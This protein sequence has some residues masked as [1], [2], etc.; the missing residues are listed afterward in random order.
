MSSLM[1]QTHKHNDIASI[2]Q[3]NAANSPNYPNKHWADK[4]T[5]K[6]EKKTNNMG[7]NQ[8]SQPITITINAAPGMDEY[9]IA[10][11]V[12]RKIRAAQR[13]AEAKSRG[14]LYD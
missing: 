3:R 14:R 1:Q 10:E 8:Y 5:S 7:G 6:K 11:V 9:A 2:I 12:S 4:Y 13:E